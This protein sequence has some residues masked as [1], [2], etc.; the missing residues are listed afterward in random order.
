MP[1]ISR[2]DL[3]KSAPLAAVAASPLALTGCA[4]TKQPPEGRAMHKGR[5]QN[6]RSPWPIC[7]DFATIRPSP[8]V[9]KVRIA[10]AAGYDAIEPWEGDLHKFEQEGGNLKDLGKAIRD[11]GLFVPSVIGL[12]G[13]IPATR[14]EFDKSLVNTRR[15]MRQAADIGAEHIQVVPQPK[16]PWEQF[17]PKWA[18]DRYREL[19]E[20]GIND[21]NIKP[22]LVFVEFL[23]GVKRMGQ[24]AA[25]AIDADH[26]QAKI[27]PDVFHMLIGGSGFNGLRHMNGEFFAIFQFNDAP[28]NMAVADMKDKDRVYPGDGVLP[29]PKILRDLHATG[30]TGCISLELYNPTYWEQDHL[31]VAKTGLEKTLR[32][33][34]QAGV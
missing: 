3:I 15:R 23:P 7:L 14:E 8:T 29:L 1:P 13:A 18:A 31:A 2:R 9:A 12:W 22:A 33:I 5:Y 28:K 4:T 20:I 11:M 24:A 32:V 26:P 34:E 17:D 16:R 10:S 21:Y 25:I 30:Y 27:I 6:N 19:I